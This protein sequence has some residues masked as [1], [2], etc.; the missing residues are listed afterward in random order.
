M[1]WRTAGKRPGM[2]RLWEPELTDRRV[3]YG[4]FSVHCHCLICE[5]SAEMDTSE[6]DYESASKHLFEAY[7][8]YPEHSIFFALGVYLDTTFVYPILDERKIEE[9]ESMLNIMDA[10]SKG[11]LYYSMADLHSYERPAQYESYLFKVIAEY[12]EF[13]RYYLD[14]GRYYFSN[15]NIEKGKLYIKEGLLR[16]NE[17]LNDASLQDFEISLYTFID[18]E[19]GGLYMFDESYKEYEEMSL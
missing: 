5:I 13:P 14:L 12:P 16:V 3:F 8:K 17:C 4:L 18:E 15:E 2:I 7:E 6:E 9:I 10:K 19:I 1:K 11:I